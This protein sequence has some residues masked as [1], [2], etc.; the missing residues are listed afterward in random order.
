MARAIYK[1]EEVKFPEYRAL[2]CTGQLG[3][4]VRFL[5]RDN[6]FKRRL[7]GDA[8]VDAE[9]VRPA[10]SRAEEEMKLGET[11][12]Q[13]AIYAESREIN[14]DAALKQAFEKIY[15]KDW[16]DHKDDGDPVVANSGEVV[17]DVVWVRDTTDIRALS[18]SSK[19]GYR[20]IIFL[21]ST[22]PDVVDLA[23]QLKA[24]VGVVCRKGGK[25]SHPAIIAREL[26]LPCLMNAGS[27]MDSFGDGELCRLKAEPGEISLD[28]VVDDGR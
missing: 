9:P 12:L 21:D 28:H 11:L 15:G 23:M 18:G 3:Q 27:Q 17:A 13:V 8:V 26:G 7:V 22:E 20:K 24:V 16:R 10:G 1:N 4:L 25:T 5:Y 6:D 14:I 19:R 2:I